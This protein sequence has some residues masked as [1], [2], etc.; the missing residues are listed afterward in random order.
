MSQ[1][2]RAR[3][4][5]IDNT[6][7]DRTRI[8]VGS[9]GNCNCSFVRQAEHESG[10]LQAC[11][12]AIVRMTASTGAHT[13]PSYVGY[14][15]SLVA[16]GATGGTQSQVAVFNLLRFVR[17]A[18]PGTGAKQSK[19]SARIAGHEAD[20]VVEG[21]NRRSIR[22]EGKLVTYIGRRGVGARRRGHA[23]YRR[24]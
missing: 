21:R 24:S 9:P 16:D 17:A 5:S 6:T 20:C 11:G 8:A 3:M 15:L 7:Q 14:K 22:N 12:T 1:R 23:D 18:F 4:R 10:S 13:T 19:K 2:V